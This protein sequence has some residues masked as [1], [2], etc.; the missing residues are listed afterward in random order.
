MYARVARFEGLD[1]GQID[2]QVAERKRQMD[3][4]RSGSL[5]DDAPPQ[6]RTLIESVKH[7]IDLVDR[8][9]GTGL[10]M[11]FTETEEDMRRADAA[12][13]EMSPEPSEGR[14]ASVEI[15]EVVLH[16]ALS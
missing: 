3:A 1:I 6:V 5:P 10:T 9:N 8:E 13:N 16:E 7:V 12:L 2:E 11:M 4:A 14:R 15:F